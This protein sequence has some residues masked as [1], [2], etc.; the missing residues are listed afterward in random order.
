MDVEGNAELKGIQSANLTTETVVRDKI[1]GTVEVSI[2]RPKDSISIR[3]VP[4]FPLR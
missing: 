3:T 1:P 2:E 4:L